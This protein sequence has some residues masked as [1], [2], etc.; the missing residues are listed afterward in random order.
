MKNILIVISVIGFILINNYLGQTLPQFSVYITAI[1]IGLIFGLL[2]F[3]T[4]YSLTLKFALMLGMLI[5]IDVLW[6][7]IISSDR[8]E[9][10]FDIVVLESIGIGISIIEAFIYG[11]IMKDNMIKKHIFLILLFC[12]I[13][14][15]YQSYFYSLGRSWINLPTT[16]IKI[17]KQKGLYISDV[18]FSDKQI[19]CDNDTIQISYGWFEQ[20]TETS[21]KRFLKKTNNT[22]NLYCTIIFDKKKW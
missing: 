22:D 9:S 7:N 18:N 13:F 1:L 15:I 5:L 10:V 14:I 17:A 12:I 2:F 16:N 3:L 21:H 8:I 19:I 20:Q 4:D 11:L 6:K